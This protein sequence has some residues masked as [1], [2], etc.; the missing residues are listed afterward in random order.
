M[1]QSSPALAIAAVMALVGCSS[2]TE[3]LEG[4]KVMSEADDDTLAGE[5]S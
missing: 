4:K 3:L 1:R 2:T 5:S